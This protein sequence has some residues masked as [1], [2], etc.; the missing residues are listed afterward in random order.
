M[1]LDSRQLSVFSR[2]TI[3][4]LVSALLNAASLFVGLY[5]QSVTL[6][7]ISGSLGCTGILFTL[8]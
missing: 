6:K 8:L 1:T 5:G 4:P 7:A 3:V 2:Q